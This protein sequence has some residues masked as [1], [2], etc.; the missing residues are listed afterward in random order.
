MYIPQEE[1]VEAEILVTSSFVELTARTS[2]ESLV[3]TVT[4]K[5]TVVTSAVLES[6]LG[7]TTEGRVEVHGFSTEHQDSTGTAIHIG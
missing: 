2:T 5:V 4:G 7:T 6:V 3:Q 1:S